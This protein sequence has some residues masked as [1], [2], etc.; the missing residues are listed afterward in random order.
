[1]KFYNI[2]SYRKHFII[3]MLFIFLQG[4]SD[5]IVTFMAYNRLRSI[6]RIKRHPGYN[7]NGI[8][9]KRGRKQKKVSLCWV[10]AQ[11]LSAF[12]FSFSCHVP[13]FFDDS[14]NG[15]CGYYGHTEGNVCKI[16]FM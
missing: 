11:V 7:K 14:T 10:V 16:I 8:S 4:A 5:L 2:I 13:F 1:M 6:S 12:I 15:A 9:F 3:N